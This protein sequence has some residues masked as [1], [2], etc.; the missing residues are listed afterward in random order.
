MMVMIIANA[1]CVPV[2][3]WHSRACPPA[4]RSHAEGGR[5]V[6]HARLS[7]G[8]LPAQ[9]G[10]TGPPRFSAPFPPHCPPWALRPP[11]GGVCLCSQSH[12][13]RCGSHSQQTK[14]SSLRAADF[15]S[16]WEV[17]ELVKCLHLLVHLGWRGGGL[18]GDFL[19]CPRPNSWNL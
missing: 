5:E 2:R 19:R 7:F 14:C 18:A 4:S 13:G 10:D 3:P 9:A 8:H 17:S 15:S 16:A 12:P 1:G 6:Q 11:T